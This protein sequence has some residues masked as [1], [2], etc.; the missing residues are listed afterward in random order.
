MALRVHYYIRTFDSI[1]SVLQYHFQKLDYLEYC[2]TTVLFGLIGI[3]INKSI[4]YL[5][6]IL[7]LVTTDTLELF[8]VGCNGTVP[9]NDRV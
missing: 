9:I 6:L 3:N 5:I 8:Y 7:S 4:P 1:H 2:M